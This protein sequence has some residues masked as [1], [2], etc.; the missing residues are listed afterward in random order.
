[1]SDVDVLVTEKL[2]AFRKQILEVLKEKHP[3]M[4]GIA[5]SAMG[6]R[7]NKFGMLVTEN[8]KV[9][10]E[11]TF[12]VDGINIES[13]EAG[14]LDSAVKHPLLGEIKP[15]AVMERSDIEA[16]LQDQEFF[17]DTFAAAK[18]LLPKTTLKFLV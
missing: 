9:A 12:L 1:M 3:Y 6:G 10:G 5:E 8:G 14:V 2:V 7:K 16:M 11:Y 18:K 13:V 4:I 15:Y 17:T